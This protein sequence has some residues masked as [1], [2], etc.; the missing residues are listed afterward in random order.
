MREFISLPDGDSYTLA[1]AS[2]PT[3]LLDGISVP[4][5]EGLGRVDIVVADG[6][7]ADIQRRS[8]RDSGQVVDLDGGQVWPC[9]I[10]MHTHL[11]KGHILHRSANP[12]GTFDGALASVTRD[13]EANWSADDVAARMDFALRCAYAHGT[14]LIRTHL[15]SKPPQEAISWPVFAEMRDSWAGRIELQAVSLISPADCLDPEAFGLVTEMVRTHGG[16]LGAVT[17]MSPELDGALDLLFQTAM[18]FG[19]DLDFHVDET[20]DPAAH[21]LRLIAEAAIRHGFKGSIVAGHCC[22]LSQQGA[23]DAGFTIDLVKHAGIKIVSLP[24]CNL[25]LQDRHFGRTPRLRGV[26]LVQELAAKGVPVAVASDNVRDPFYAYGDLDMV[27]VLREAVRVLHLDHPLDNVA[28]LVTRGPAA[29][30]GRPELGCLRVG[31]PA[32]LVLFSAR[33]WTEFFARPQMDRVVVRDGQAIDRML[34]DY[35]ELD[36]L[37]GAMT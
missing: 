21:S 34:P 14:K 9:F 19:L 22:S 8:E 29:I 36:H 20:L 15:D 7:I 17:Y 23:P 25:Y 2:V 10:D 3:V 11:D 31:D 28:R 26:T 13:R 33:D 27:E 6:R 4:D 5:R 16:V 12:T 35:R 30:V 18:T 1:N 24:M 37:S 32:D